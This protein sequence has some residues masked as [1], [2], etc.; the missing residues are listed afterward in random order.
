MK[1]KRVRKVELKG[2]LHEYYELM[3]LL[4]SRSHSFSKLNLVRFA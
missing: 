3:K 4:G 2:Q 1:R